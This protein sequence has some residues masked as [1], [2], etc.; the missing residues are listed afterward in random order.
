MQK[1]INPIYYSAEDIDNKI[2]HCEQ[3]YRNKNMRVAFKM[4]NEAF[5]ESLDCIL[6]ELT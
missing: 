5:P 6:Q 4:T 2:D 1:E 3:I